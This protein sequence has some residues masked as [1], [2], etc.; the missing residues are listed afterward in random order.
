METKLE[1]ISFEL[2]EFTMLRV[3][4]GFQLLKN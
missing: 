2:V 4:L 1:G 3:D